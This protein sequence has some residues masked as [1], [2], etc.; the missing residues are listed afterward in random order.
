MFAYCFIALIV[1]FCL[2]PMGMILIGSLTDNNAILRN[3]YSFFP[4]K[5]SLDAYR[6]IFAS[7]GEIARAYGI[8]IFVT[9]TGTFGGLFITTLAGYVLTCR[10]FRWRNRFAFFF[11]FTTLF[12]GGMVPFY[13][14]VASVLGLKDHLLAIILPGLTSPFLIILMR[15]FIQTSIPVSLAESMR[16]DGATDF[17]I[18]F[19]L[20]LPLIKPALA[21]V[22]L[23]LALNYW[24]GW[25]YPM[26][27]LS[28]PSDYPIQYYLYNMMSVQRMAA[29][30]GA[31]AGMQF[32]GESIK[33]AMAVIATVPIL[34]AY[35]F[36][37]RYFVE[38]LTV[39]AVKE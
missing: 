8:T 31:A 12:S 10:N 36:V 34:L 24:N 32:P 39:G 2:L 28:R 37:Q 6:Y 14:M 3:G 21:T 5:F 30:S 13:I 33:M 22:G 11:Y 9:L 35:P 4:E 7:F 16:M 1:L 27:F 19:R 15:S 17:T 20:V 23:F 18:F 38:G 25:Y 26:L 29:A